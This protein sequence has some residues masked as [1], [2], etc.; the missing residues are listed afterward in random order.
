MEYLYVIIKFDGNNGE[1]W[2]SLGMLIYIV[3]FGV[4]KIDNYFYRLLLFYDGWF[5][6]GILGLLKCFVEIV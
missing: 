6:I 4:I 5:L 2:G 3:N 1:V